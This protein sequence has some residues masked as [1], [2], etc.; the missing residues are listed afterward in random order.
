MEADDEKVNGAIASH[1]AEVAAAVAK[2][3]ELGVTG[4]SH[5]VVTVLVTTQH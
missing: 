3:V 4:N 5:A 2:L 1:S